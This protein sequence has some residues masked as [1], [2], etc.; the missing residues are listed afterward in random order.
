[1]IT[2]GAV[3][4]VEPLGVDDLGEDLEGHGVGW[5]VYRVHLAIGNGVTS[6]L[7]CVNR[8]DGLTRMHMRHTDAPI[9][10]A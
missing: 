2:P 4:N 10:G 6:T 3:V 9:P 8:T 7:F 1:M 5:R